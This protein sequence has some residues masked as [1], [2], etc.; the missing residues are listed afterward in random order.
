MCYTP[1]HT[2]QMQANAGKECSQCRAERAANE[3][4][5]RAVSFD[6]FSCHGECR[7]GRGSGMAGRVGGGVHHTEEA[8]YY[9]KPAGWQ[10]RVGQG[11]DTGAGPS[12]AAIT[13][14][15]QWRGLQCSLLH[16]FTAAC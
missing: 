3:G 7:G 13:C 2:C 9:R 1:C 8:G 4:R 15:P 5:R 6:G 14:I 12:D 11:S 16:H 10:L